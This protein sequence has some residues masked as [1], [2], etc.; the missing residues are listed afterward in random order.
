MTRKVS[1]ISIFLVLF[2]ISSEAKPGPGAP[3]GL[4]CELLRDPAHAVITDQSPEFGW[5]VNDKRRDARQAAFQVLVATGSNCINSNKGDMWNSG[6]VISN[7]SVNIEYKGKPLQPHTEYWWKVKTWDANGRPGPFS[8][9][10]KFI[11]G[12]FKSIKRRWP[13]ESRWIKTSDTCNRSV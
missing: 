13:A 9:P 2:S 8:N 1:A 3:S 5:I 6:K 7:H 11:T 4:L 10:Q 12:T